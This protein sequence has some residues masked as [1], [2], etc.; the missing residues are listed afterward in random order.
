MKIKIL[1]YFNLDLI[2]FALAI[3][4]VVIELAI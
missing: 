2:F 4:L 3:I 1:E